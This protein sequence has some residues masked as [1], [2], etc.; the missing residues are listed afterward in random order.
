MTLRLSHN[1]E[2]AA[3]AAYDRRDAL[4][5]RILDGKRWPPLSRLAERY[6]GDYG[7]AI[8]AA[9]KESLPDGADYDRDVLWDLTEAACYMKAHRAAYG[10]RHPHDVPGAAAPRSDG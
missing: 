7:V 6:I 2:S 8:A 10:Q 3:A 1:F 4:M 9:Y 5:N